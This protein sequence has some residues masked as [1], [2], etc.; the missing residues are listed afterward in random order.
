M[1]TFFSPAAKPNLIQFGDCY[2]NE[3]RTLNLTMTNHSKT[4]CVRFQWP[5]HPQVKFSPQVR[6]PLSVVEQ[7]LLT[8]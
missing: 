4:D 2:V 7:K 5:E 1:F 8:Q 6:K 3:N